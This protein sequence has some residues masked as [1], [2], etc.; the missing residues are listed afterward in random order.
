M[1]IYLTKMTLNTESRAVWNDLGNLQQLHK[2]ISKAFPVIENREHLAH[3][4]RE[5]PRNKFNLLHRLD[6]DRR[7]GKAVLLVQSA[8][9]P[10]WD[11]L[12]DNY[13]DEIKC[14]EVSEQYAAIFNGQRL[15]FRLHANPTKRIGK[16]DGRA[17]DK[18]K[19]YEKGANRRRVELRTDDEKIEWLKRKGLDA[20]FRLANVRIKETVANV[21]TVAGGK[22]KSR[23][24]DSDKPMTFGAV[25]FEGILEVT[26]AE[27][28]R[29]SLKQ[30]IGTGKA[31]GFGLLSVVK[32]AEIES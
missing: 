7:S 5:T 15:L 10:N 14:K 31:Y 2:T 32:A 21:A 16:S 29:E 17:A 30:G 6:F 22:I 20:G 12:A 3:H 27:K 25:T 28:I 19:Q 24:N 23:R 11:F 18:F 4:E 8:I 13:A 26:N 9:S 1:E